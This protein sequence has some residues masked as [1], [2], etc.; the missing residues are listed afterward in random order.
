MD[1]REKWVVLPTQCASGLK[2]GCVEVFWEPREGQ[3]TGEAGKA[4]KLSLKGQ[5]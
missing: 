1:G 5:V 4:A 3:L 2:L